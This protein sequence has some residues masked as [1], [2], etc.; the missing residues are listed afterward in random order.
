MGVPRTVAKLVYVVYPVHIAGK[1]R[2][3]LVPSEPS[4]VRYEIIFNILTV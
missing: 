1:A 2:D 3:L 4:T